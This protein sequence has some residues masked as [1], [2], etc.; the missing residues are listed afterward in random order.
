MELRHHLEKN[1]KRLRMPAVMDNLDL[2]VQQAE[3]SRLGYIEFLSLLVQDE[4]ASREANNLKKRLKL[5]G[6]GQERTFEGFDFHFNEPEL[7]SSTIRD[8][9]TCHF[10]E[11]RRN[12]VLGGPPGIG[13]YV[14]HSLM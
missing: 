1:L 6:F 5:A 11:Q 9:A 3:D 2:R 4:I 14:K 10:V 12:L 13:N 8:L 7:P